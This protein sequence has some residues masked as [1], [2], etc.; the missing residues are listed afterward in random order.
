MN[1]VGNV[2]RNTLT[3][4]IGLEVR[5]HA[6]AI[7]NAA[8][9]ALDRGTFYRYTLVNRNTFPLTDAR[10]AM[11]TDP[12][13]GDASDDYVGTDVGRSM[14]YVYNADND[15]T[16]GYGANP[17]AVGVDL[18]NGL[19]ASMYFQ[20]GALIPQRD[21]ADGVQMFEVMQGRWTDGTAMT[22]GGTGLNPGSTNETRFAFSGNP[23]ANEFWS[24][25]C[26]NQPCGSPLMPADLRTVG[27]TVFHLDPG[28]A[29]SF[30]VAIL[31]ARGT[32]NLNSITQL[33]AASDLVQG[34]YDAGTLFPSP[35]DPPVAN[36]QSPTAP[37]LSL[38]VTP[39][40]IAAAGAIRYQLPEAGAARVAVYDVL[41]RELV[42]LADGPAPAGRREAALDAGRLAPGV[43]VVALETPAGRAARTFTVIR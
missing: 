33:R 36:G 10:V 39:N 3:A 38:D 31:Y 26:P 41:G 14:S 8:Q 30:D 37:S 16:G 7:D 6:F 42:V 9:P 23:V 12:D 43:Y 19:Y 24:M 40:P 1:D 25:R 32:S 17:P 20:N 29:R 13:L 18:L 5:V 2:H 22:E 11:F 4:P 28:Q 27:S 15:D 35:L 21:P 34:L